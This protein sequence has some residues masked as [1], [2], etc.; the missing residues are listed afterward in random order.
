MLNELSLAARRRAVLLFLA[1]VLAAVLVWSVQRGRPVP[2]PETAATAVATLPC[3]SYA[4]FRRPGATPFDPELRVTR[5]EIEADLRLLATVTGC[6][7]TYGVDHGLDVVPDVAR[8]LGLRVILGAWIGRDAVANQAQLARALAL[9]QTYRDV[10]ELLIVGNEVLLR[11]EL[12]PEALAA[13]LMQARSASPVPVSYADVWA[14]WLRHA[15]VLRPHVD[16][17]ATHI[18]PYWEDEPIG[19]DGAVDHI[20]AIAG[21]LRQV[22]GTTPVYVAETG[23]PAAGRQRGPAVPGRLEQARF[24]R[25]L[26]ARQHETPMLFNLIEGFDQPWKRNLEGAMGG[27]WG[28]FDAGGVLRV[29]LAGP[30]VPDPHWPVLPVS[31]LLGGLLMGLAGRR[32]DGRQMP[33][34][35]VGGALTGLFAGWQ[36][37]DLPLWSRDVWEWLA[38]SARIAA[39]VLCGLAASAGL[40]G[41]KERRLVFTSLPLLV[42]AAIDAGWLVFDARYRPLPW[43]MLAAPAMLL[44]ASAGLGHRRPAFLVVRTAAWLCAA[45]AVLVAVNEGVANTQALLYAGLLLTLAVSMLC[46]HR[47]GST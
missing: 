18:L 35:L 20:Y 39:S 28:L 17:V 9:A 44:L 34:L 8:Q 23:W 45:G 37:Q 15:E 3:L 16:L 12:T 14:F 36:L 6:V 41:W 42:I 4:P 46:L 10:V 29:L 26:L 24:V 31:A 32:I 30:V 1:G 13:L 25:E 5:A 27:A 11:R 40:A 22:F 19:I 47:A 21:Q 43:P 2:L 7:R 38:G 33:F